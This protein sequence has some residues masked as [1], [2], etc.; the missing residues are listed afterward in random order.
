MYLIVVTL[1]LWYYYWGTGYYTKN[2]F[3]VSVAQI[4][5]L[6]LPCIYYN[7]RPVE[8]WDFSPLNCSKLHTATITQW[9]T[10]HNSDV[11]TQKRF[12]CNK[13]IKWSPVHQ[14]ILISRIC[15]TFIRCHTNSF[16]NLAQGRCLD[17]PQGIFILKSSS[18]VS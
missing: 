3:H 6:E 8:W 11:G 4:H 9:S 14:T 12:N 15:F 17:L 7:W 10:I 16:D 5:F 13:R 2:D 18:Y 1:S